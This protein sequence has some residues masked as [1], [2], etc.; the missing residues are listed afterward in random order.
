[1]QLN[2]VKISKTLL[3]VIG[4]ILWENAPYEMEYIYNYANYVKRP[5]LCSVTSKTLRRL[6]STSFDT[7]WLKL[8]LHFCKM[9]LLLI[10]K[11]LARKKNNNQAMTVLKLKSVSGL[12]IWHFILLYMGVS[13]PS[14]LIECTNSICTFID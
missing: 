5:S 13:G 1:M 7:T 4:I 14:L 10:G 9:F 3:K 8:V 12:S 11:K 6:Q 2:A